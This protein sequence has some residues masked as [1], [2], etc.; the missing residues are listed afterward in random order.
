M[1]ARR[2]CG[3]RNGLGV[4]PAP[5]TP[6]VITEPA[7]YGS[8]TATSQ[9]RARTDT[10][11]NPCG[12]PRSA[13]FAHPELLYHDLEQAP[14]RGPS[15]GHA[16]HRCGGCHPVDAQWNPQLRL[17][18]NDQDRS[19][20]SSWASGKRGRAVPNGPSFPVEVPGGHSHPSLGRLQVAQGCPGQPRTRRLPERVEIESFALVIHRQQKVVSKVVSFFDRTH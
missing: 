6:E 9:C 11:I 19:A 7:H 4:A 5:P 15:T 18:L 2:S 8:R 14:R 17:G 20:G 16:A 1:G 3:G 12:P 10:M 13:D